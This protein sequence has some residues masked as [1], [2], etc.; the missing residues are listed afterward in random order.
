M[1]SNQAN[2]S[3]GFN[4]QRMS[5]GRNSEQYPLRKKEHSIPNV[6]NSRM[7]NIRRMEKSHTMSN[8][9]TTSS[10]IGNNSQ[11]YDN[12]KQSYENEFIILDSSEDSYSN[13]VN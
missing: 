3:K 5:E 6:T 2:N 13:D 8:S 12:H 9:Q 7:I 11:N 1:A 4:M 10:N